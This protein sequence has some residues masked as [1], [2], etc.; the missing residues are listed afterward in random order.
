[1]R[2][3]RLT[4]FCLCVTLLAIAA[5]TFAQDFRGRI[6]G[7]VTDNTGA[8]LPGVTVTASSPALIQ[9]QVQVTGADGSF[10]FLALPPGVYEIDFELTGF[11]KVKRKDVRVVINQTLTRRHAAASRDAAGD[12]HRHRRLADRRHL[13]DHHGHQLHQGTAHRNPERPRRLGGHGAGARHADDG[14][15]RR[16]LEHRHA[17]R[18]PLLRPRHAEPDP[19]RRHRHHRR[20]RGQRRLLRLRQL[21]R[22][23][24]RRRRRATRGRSPA[25][26]C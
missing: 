24:G 26:R 9:P 1:M 6:N 15:R 5:P 14:V 22:V 3:N 17:D 13:D 18:L 11:Q 19:H 21:R 12:R 16:R 8:I 23:P 10:R 2:L 7:T 25:A 4:V 20:H